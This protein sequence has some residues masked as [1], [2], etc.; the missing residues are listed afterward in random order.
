MT[1]PFVSIK[2]SKYLSVGWQR[3]AENLIAVESC[4]LRLSS[5]NTVSVVC[6]LTL[7][8]P[9]TLGFATRR[10]GLI[11]DLRVY[12]GVEYGADLILSRIIVFSF[13]K[14][15]RVTKVGNFS[16]AI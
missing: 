6:S 2:N 3:I 5:E 9:P 8:R 11:Y 10:A 12:H 15:D 13:T 14:D 1:F 4:P 16:R 7:S